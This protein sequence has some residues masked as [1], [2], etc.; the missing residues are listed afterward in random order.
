[1][2]SALEGSVMKYRCPVVSSVSCLGQVIGMALAL[3]V[4]TSA[5]AQHAGDVYVADDDGVLVTG[6]IIGGETI[7]VPETVF[8]ST[9]NAN[10]F[11]SN[12]GFDTTPQMF[13]VGTRLGFNLRSPLEIWTGCG[14]DPAVDA[15]LRVSF[16]TVA[17]DSGDG[18]VPGFD[19]AVEGNGGWH[20]H[21]THNVRSLPDDGVAPNGIYLME[22]EL[23]STDTDLETSA[24]F[25]FVYA[26]GADPEELD[27]AVGW[28]LSHKAHDPSCRAD[29]TP[30]LPDGSVGNGMVNIDDLLAVVNS[31]GALEGPC[32]L[33][34]ANCDGTFGNGDINI[35]D[36][37]FVINN[38]G[39]TCATP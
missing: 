8:V 14:F 30:V 1:M 19:L 18:F 22:F 9:L 6:A 34:P 13:D 3:L 26:F 33:Q 28:T 2:R 24:P 39:L 10:G 31:F 7:S 17:V 4:V 32:D 27:R 15:G 5:R 21:L 16:F 38:F 37:L 29:C 25:W 20:K 36:L 12:P 11:S 23:Y 35:D